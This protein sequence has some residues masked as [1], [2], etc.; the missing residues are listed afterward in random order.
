MYTYTYTDM[1]GLGVRFPR[2]MN[3]Q[4]G[5]YLVLAILQRERE[6]SE[7]VYTKGLKG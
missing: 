1:R 3:Q 6:M 2:Q 5:M 7:R 4:S